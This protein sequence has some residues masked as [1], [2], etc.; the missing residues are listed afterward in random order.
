VTAALAD[1][2]VMGLVRHNLILAT[3]SAQVGPAENAQVAEPIQSA[4]DR[5]EIHIAPVERSL[6]V[7]TLGAGMAAELAEGLKDCDPLSRHPQAMLP[8]PIY[9]CLEIIHRN[10]LAK[11]CK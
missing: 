11:I 9:H 3:A 8:R 1:Q 10:L 2:V 7:D 5:G 4:I 6:F